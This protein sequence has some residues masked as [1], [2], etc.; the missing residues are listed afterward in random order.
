M[1]ALGIAL[2][3]MRD[4][5]IW[6]MPLDHI[7]YLLV[8]LLLGAVIFGLI[9]AIVGIMAFWVVEIWPLT[10]MVE[11]VMYLFGGTL[12]PILL[13]PPT[14]QRLTEFLPFRYIFYEPVNLLLGN[15]PDPMSVIVR[16][17]IF[18]AILY[19]IYQLVW[20]AGI[21][22]YEGIGG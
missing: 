12:A 7:P 3:F 8:V 13:L 17:G 1:P 11:I 19:V 6:Q 15:Q 20:K 9:E 22:R 4:Y 5:I 21:R 18:V 16:Q 2:Y 14:I 10:D